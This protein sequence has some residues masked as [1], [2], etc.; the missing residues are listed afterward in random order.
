MKKKYVLSSLVGGAFFATSYLLLQLGIAPSLLITAVTFGASSMIFKDDYDL[1]DL[2]ISNA[3]EYKKLLLN[4]GE[5]LKKLKGMVNKI[6][7]SKISEKVVNITKIT[8]KIFKV[9]NKN[10]HKIAS[11]SKFLEYYLPVTI[12][13]LEK[14]DEIE[15]QGLTSDSSL[16]LL[17]RIRNLIVNIEIA[18]ENQL[19]NLYNDDVTDTSAEIS[20]FETML[21]SDGLLGDSIGYKKDGDNNE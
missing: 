14:F 4:S 18:F 1:K 13:I 12:R 17:D 3:E 15:D 16:E 7:D 11:A 5:N 19:N 9:L 8:D 21:K 6:N 10:S 2:G 20:V